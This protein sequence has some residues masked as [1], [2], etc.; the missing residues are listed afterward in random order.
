MVALCS[1]TGC[2]SYD[3][4]QEACNAPFMSSDI[5]FLTLCSIYSGVYRFGMLLSRYVHVFLVH[6]HLRKHA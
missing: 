6:A 3:A 5:D 2:A 4:W 1:Q